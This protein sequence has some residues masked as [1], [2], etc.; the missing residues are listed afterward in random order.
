MGN[1][2]F[3]YRIFLA[4]IAID[5]KLTEVKSKDIIVQQNVIVLEFWLLEASK[6]E[7]YSY[8]M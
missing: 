2:T 3:T 4:C 5:L 6:Y 1:D 7:A 8:G